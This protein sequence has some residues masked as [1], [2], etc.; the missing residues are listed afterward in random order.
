MLVDALRQ[1]EL[2][3]SASEILA[4]MGDLE[5]NVA[6]EV[7]REKPQSEF[8]CDEPDGFGKEIEIGIVEEI[9]GDREVPLQHGFAQHRIEVHVL[10]LRRFFAV[11]IA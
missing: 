3:Q 9:T 6:F 5:V 7:I 2:D 1:S 8:E 4:S 10:P 11:R